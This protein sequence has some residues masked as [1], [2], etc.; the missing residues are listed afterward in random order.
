[1]LSS[2]TDKLII[3]TETPGWRKIHLPLP[4]ISK[5]DELHTTI[6]S[7]KASFHVSSQHEEKQFGYTLSRRDSTEMK[8]CQGTL[9]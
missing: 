2:A 6:W 5:R 1:M 8:L 7:V 9:T 4:L 3:I